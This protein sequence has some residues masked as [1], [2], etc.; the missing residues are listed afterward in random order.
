MSFTTAQVEAMRAAIATGALTVRNANGEM[1][2]YRSLS[3]MKD[4][5]GMMEASVSGAP[6]TAYVNPVFDRGL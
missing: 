1:V 5:L 4:V 3:E 6:R 2:T